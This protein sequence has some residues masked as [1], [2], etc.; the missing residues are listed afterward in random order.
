MAAG[1]IA[2]LLYAALPLPAG[3]GAVVSRIVETLQPTLIFAMLFVTFCKISPSEL[4]PCRWHAWLMLIQVALF[5]LL[6]GILVLFPEIPGRLLIESAMICFI[7]PTACAAA[8]VCAKLGGNAAHLT[9]YILL[10]NMAG[11]LVIPLIVPL[12]NPHEGQT[13][14]TTFLLVLRRVFPTLIC[15]LMLAWGI[16]YTLPRLARRLQNTGDTAFYLWTL[17]LTMAIGVTTRSIAHS[18]VPLPTLIGIALVALA[19]CWTQF[20]IG[21][22]FGAPQGDRI[23]AGQAMGQKNTVF[24]IWMAYTFL[25]PVTAIAGGFY[26]VWHNCFNSYQLYKKR[27]ASEDTNLR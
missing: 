3:T 27:K 19:C 20:T 11:A 9:G 13:F 17:A 8:V 5:A 23:A 4:K 12:V 1:V 18:D 25:T 6:A 16:R 15:P 14:I 10:I 22:K 24:A 7:C 2:Y 26:S 21:R